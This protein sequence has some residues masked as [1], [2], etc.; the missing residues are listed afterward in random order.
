MKIR[1][2]LTN[3]KF[4]RLT[5]LEFDHNDKWGHPHW[6]C[7][8][9]CGKIKTIMGDSLSKKVTKSCGCLQKELAREN[10]RLPKG[11]AGFNLLYYVYKRSAKL[12]DKYFDKSL[13]FKEY[14]RKLTKENC[15]YCGAEPKQEVK[16]NGNKRTQDSIE[17]SKYIYNGID[18]V[19]SDKGYTIDN[20]VTCCKLCNYAKRV[21]SQEAFIELI[22][23]I[24]NNLKDKGIIN[25]TVKK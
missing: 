10:Q 14:F 7:I 23:N 4:G 15:Y 3:K 6:K 25:D 19:D 17:Y 18:R 21:L 20:T 9:E 11:E 13:E 12:D 22:K 24:Y 8:C 16:S 2:D 1:V 5:V